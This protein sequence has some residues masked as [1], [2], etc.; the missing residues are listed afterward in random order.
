LA[1]LHKLLPQLEE[2]FSVKPPVLPL[3]VVAYLAV[4]V[5]NKL[6]PHFLEGNSKNRKRKV[7]G[8]LGRLRHLPQYLHLVPQPLLQLKVAVFLEA[9]LK[10]K[11]QVSSE[12]LLQPPLSNL[13]PVYS[14]VQ[15][16]L[17][18]LNPKLASLA[19][20]GLL[21]LLLQPNLSLVSLLSSSISNQ[22]EA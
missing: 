22:L 3:Q 1:E 6:P 14:E 4:L 19:V 2:A 9:P 10:L 7:P 20:V 12:V 15:Q 11:A 16:Q 5:L 17:P 21:V 18:L 8:F 13:K